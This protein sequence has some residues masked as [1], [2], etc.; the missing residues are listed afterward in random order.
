MGMV[1]GLVTI[2][3]PITA[4]VC[5]FLFLM[6]WLQLRHARARNEQDTALSRRLEELQARVEARDR[7][8]EGL[9]ERV[10][11]L[12]R[13]VTDDSTKLRDDIDRLRA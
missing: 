1:P 9:E 3:V 13:I 11:V 12:E 5:T 2:L 8:I 7:A 4:I 10:R 6:R